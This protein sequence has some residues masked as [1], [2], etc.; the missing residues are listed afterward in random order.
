MTDNVRTISLAVT[1]QVAGRPDA[2]EI[3]SSV[4]EDFTVSPVE[5]QV[6]VEVTVAGQSDSERSALFIDEA[7]ALPR[8]DVSA[9]IASSQEWSTADGAI[10]RVGQPI[11]IVVLLG[12]DNQPGSEV[13]TYGPFTGQSGLSSWRETRE[14]IE[15]NLSITGG[16]PSRWVACELKAPDEA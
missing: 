11:Y 16:D 5:G 12:K 6:D 2:E 7:H 1:V 15:D 14:F 8:G 3:A 13:A 10:T 4:R 9:V